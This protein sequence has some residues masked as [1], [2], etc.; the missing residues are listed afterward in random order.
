MNRSRGVRPAA[1]RSSAADDLVDIAAQHRRQIGVDDAGVAAADQLDQRLDLV[2]G[3]DLG[4]ADLAR[5]ARRAPPR[6]RSSAS[7][8][9]ARSRSRDSR[10]SNAV[11]QI[12]ARR[13]EVER[14]QHFAVG[15][16]PF[17]DLDRR[18]RKAARAGRCGARR[19][20][21]A[22]GSRSAAR[23]RSPLVMASTTGSPLRSSKALV[24]TVVP[25]FTLVDRAAAGLR[26]RAAPDPGDRGV[27][28][29]A[30]DCRRAVCGSTS[31]PSGARATMSVKVPP[32]SIEKV[33]PLTARA[34]RSAGACRSRSWAE[35]RRT[36]ARAD[37]CRAR[38]PP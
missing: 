11:S 36:P 20:P 21:A 26:R 6:A 28:D 18:R 14:P 24:A 32:R 33:Q 4:E 2:A 1:S 31:R 17:V 19:C 10:A 22:P 27:V 34:A 38:S 9:S 3:R 5:R 23:R 37:I 30:R 7:R 12:R 15:A 8:A 29:S 16:H 35:R 13:V 25:I